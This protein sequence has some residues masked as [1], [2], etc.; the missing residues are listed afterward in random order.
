MSEKA[1]FGC[2]DR[3]YWI[4]FRS[5]PKQKDDKQRTLKSLEGEPIGGF[6]AIGAD[7]AV[8]VFGLFQ[9]FRPVCLEGM[10][11]GQADA[12]GWP[13]ESAMKLAALFSHV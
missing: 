11:A 6:H 13:I 3:P 9:R 10:E 4:R 5:F 1:E 12:L 7:L 8:F 2:V